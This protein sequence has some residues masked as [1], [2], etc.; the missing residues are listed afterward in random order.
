MCRLISGVNEICFVWVGVNKIL[1]QI[2]SLNR[3]KNIYV[4]DTLISQN[5]SLLWKCDCIYKVIFLFRPL[6]DIRCK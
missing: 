6:Y 5:V 4:F 2:T 1:C 3:K